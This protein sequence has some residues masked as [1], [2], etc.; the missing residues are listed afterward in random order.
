[1]VFLERSVV[2]NRPSLPPPDVLS[3]RL[4]AVLELFKPFNR[5]DAP[6]CVVGIAWAGHVVVR[7]A[8]GLASVRHGVA[9]TPRTRMRI[10]STSKH[11]TCLAALMLAEE[12]RLDL[13]GPASQALPMLDLSG[14]HDTPSL[15]QFMNHTSG[16]R[17]AL[18]LSMIGNGFA[19][20]PPG[21]MP[22]TVAQQQGRNFAPSHGQIY[23]NSGYHLLSMA[24][25]HAAGMPL[26]QFLKQRVFAP[27]GMDDT[28]GVPSDTRVTR[29]MASSH[30]PDPSGGWRHAHC[31]TEEI[32][33]EGNI[34]STVDDMLRWM[35]HLRGPKRVGSDAAWRQLLEPTVLADGTSS[36]YGLGLLKRPYRGLE[37]IE[38]PGGVA[39]GNSQMLTVPAHGL[40][41]ALMSNGVM[42]SMRDLAPRILDILLSDQ[43]APAP[44]CAELSRFQHLVGA[45]Y[46]GPS[47]RLVAFG[48]AGDRLGLSFMDN[49][50]FIPLRDEGDH[51]RIRFE[52]TTTCDLWLR[53]DELSGTADP[54]PP[55]QLQLRDGGHLETL[56]RLPVVAPNPEVVGASLV[57]SWFCHD[58]QATAEIVLEDGVLGL[59]LRGS[60]SAKR[61]LALSPLSNT[62]FSVVDPGLPMGGRWVLTCEID[63]GPRAERFTL[64]G[65][66]TR[67]LAFTRT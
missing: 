42:A 61:R 64:D 25:D 11:F 57:G 65:P 12:G 67:Q 21:W 36:A 50:P 39:G 14:F 33:G 46:H 23:S 1:M 29:D 10:G 4:A 62:A 51:L 37:T 18:D 28:E 55:A 13:D 48:A 54:Q 63:Q 66:R 31:A 8:F 58:L 56:V 22:A 19:L 24:I 47:G 59:W 41:I 17:C 38:H 49:P 34:V 35:A 7:Q 20:M 2:P 16:W 5:A 6:G 32:R 27:L 3:D 52:D 9:N 53:S 44:P 26:E 43:L 40:D 15:R 60:Y 45:S 30:F